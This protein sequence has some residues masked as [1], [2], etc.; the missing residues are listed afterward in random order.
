MDSLLVMLPDHARE[1]IELVIHVLVAGFG[2]AMAYNGWI[3]GASVGTVKIPN[4]GL[5]EV[6]RYVPLIASGVL[7][8]SF[9]IEHII[10]LLRGEEV[11]PSWN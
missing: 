4:L 7:I 10:A 1:K 9:S 8:V 3:L 2:V 6:I 5:P 11:V